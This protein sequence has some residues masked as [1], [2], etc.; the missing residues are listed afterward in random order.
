[1]HSPPGAVPVLI[2]CCDKF[3]IYELKEVIEVHAMSVSKA[4][5]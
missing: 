5:R 3:F 2:D 4:G 1:M